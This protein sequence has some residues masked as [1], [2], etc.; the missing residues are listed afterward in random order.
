M[1]VAMFLLNLFLPII[2]LLFNLWFMLKLKFCIPPSVQLGLDLDA[3]LTVI[4]GGV[5]FAAGI[6]I[7]ILTG[8]DQTSLQTTLRSGLNT[9]SPGLGDQLTAEMTNNAI[10]QALVAQGIGTAGTQSYP[11]SLPPEPRVTRDEV[12]HP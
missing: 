6:D 8:V 9:V 10:V 1:I 4:P 12:V 2:L 7:D 11:S 5:E 3:E